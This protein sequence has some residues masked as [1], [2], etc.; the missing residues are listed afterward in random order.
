MAGDAVLV[1]QERAQ[2]RAVHAVRRERR[3]ERIGQRDR[4]KLRRLEQSQYIFPFLRR[5]FAQRTKRVAKF[6]K[7]HNAAPYLMPMIA[8]PRRRVKRFGFEGLS[9]RG[10]PL[11][12]ASLAISSAR[13]R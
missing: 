6:I 13:C 3:R 10:M 12:T 8:G 1:G 7:L 11:R 9:R 4:G 2:L 5:F